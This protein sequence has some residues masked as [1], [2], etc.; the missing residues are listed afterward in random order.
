MNL[1]LDYYQQ[2]LIQERKRILNQIDKFDDNGYAGLKNS[3]RES[4]SGLSNYDNHPADSGNTTFER[5][6]DIGLQD[7]AKVM[8]TM[9]DDALEKIES[10]QYGSC[11]YCG[12]DIN[13]K[14]LEAMP[15]TTICIDCKNDFETSENI[16]DRPLEEATMND[17]FDTGGYFRLTDD[18][19]N[20]AFDGEDTW[21]S[22]A[23]V[24]T[25]NTPSDVPG[26]RNAL[27][28]Y[29]DADEWPYQDLYEDEL[30][31]IFEDKE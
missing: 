26:A 29:I 17:Y 9:I 16:S 24:G 2:K 12:E 6:K 8:L 14:R 11:D 18:S 7:N 4:T 31:D 21:Q 13:S 19:E 23:S 27:D 25:S 30:K 1:N 5:E 15:H 28:S 10:G 22:L 3:I 20:T